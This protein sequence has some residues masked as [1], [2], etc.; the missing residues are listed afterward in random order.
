MS[1]L[2]DI[3]HTRGILSKMEDTMIHVPDIIT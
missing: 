3:Q 2:E 1:T